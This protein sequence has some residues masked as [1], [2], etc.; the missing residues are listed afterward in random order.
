MP[1]PTTPSSAATRRH[2]LSRRTF[3]TSTATA[4]TTA[5]LATPALLTAAKTD[6][7]P[8]VG[9]GDYV[10]SVD[11]HW[12][13]LPE[14]YTWQTTH[15][16]AI[17]S[18]GLVYIIHEG[19][20]R[21]KE[22]PSIFVFDTEGNFVRA[23]GEQYQGGGHG[24]EV[25]REGSDQFLYITAYQHLK[26]FT[27]TDLKGERVWQKWAPMEAG[28]YAENEGSAPTGQWGRDR[29][30]PTN[31]AFHPEGGFYLADGYGA[32]CV[33][34]Y[35]AHGKWLSKFG[36]VGTGDGQFQTPHGIWIDDRRGRSPSVVVADRAN[37]RLQ[38]FSLD[39]EHQ[40]TMDGFFLPANIDTF[41]ELM[42]I[43]DLQARVT[44]LDGDNNIVAQLGDDEA[45]RGEVM[46][47]NRAMRSHPDQWQAGRFIH[48]HDACFD[49][50][51]NI[52]V[53]EWVAGGRITKMTRHA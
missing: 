51:G 28:I 8:T 24:L 37:G 12:A 48:P 27:K 4:T 52:F 3:L 10:Y 34:R 42:L 35:D 40:H 13:Q 32:W 20:A 29:F 15:N 26:T 18:N 53:A 23:F 6:S 22:H 50:D 31:T 41:G 11:H 30:M 17:D 33:H 16:V 19:D 43:P 7:R 47:D 38:W 2:N 14:R 9:Q 25:H 46:K 45:W 5:I 1:T 36:S 49:H 39:G 21:Q 44:L